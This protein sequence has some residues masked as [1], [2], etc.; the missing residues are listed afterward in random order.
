MQDL[1]LLPAVEAGPRLVDWRALYEEKEGEYER[2]K[3]VSAQRM[4]VLWTQEDQQKSS[5]CAQ[6]LP[7]S[8]CH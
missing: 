5:R 1:P 4:R 6:V 3:Q 8:R 2:A 7:H